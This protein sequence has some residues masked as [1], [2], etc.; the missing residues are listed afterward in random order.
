MDRQTGG[1]KNKQSTDRP[2][3][4]AYEWT[5][6]RTDGRTVMRVSSGSSSGMEE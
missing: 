5:R 1:R 4:L 2:A 3:S 6:G